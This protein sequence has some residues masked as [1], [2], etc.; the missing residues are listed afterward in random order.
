MLAPRKKL[1][2]TPSSAV[3][4]AL[5]LADLD[6]HDVVYDIG[7]GD[8]RVLIQLASAS[9][10][11]PSPSQ[12]DDTLETP[13][14]KEHE[15]EADG[16]CNG[17]D[18]SGGAEG[19]TNGCDRVDTSSEAPSPPSK[20]EQV[21]SFASPTTIPSDPQQQL[22]E[23]SNQRNDP[24]DRPNQNH[25]TRRHHHC[26]KFV[27]IE[28]SPERALE[29]QTNVQNA[30]RS[31][32]VPEHVAIEIRCMNALEVNYAHDATVCFLY[33]VPRG[34]RLMKPLLWGVNQVK[35]GGIGGA[36]GKECM[37]VD[38]GVDDGAIIACSEGGNDGLDAEES[39]RNEG[40]MD[41]KCQNDVGE[42]D[43]GVTNAVV[44]GECDEE[45]MLSSTAT[46]TLS[47]IV[48]NEQDEEKSHQGGTT[49]DDHDDSCMNEHNNMGR[50]M[51]KPRRIITYMAGFEDEQYVRKEHCQVEHQEGAA[52][53]IYLYHVNVV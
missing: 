18:G 15:N 35:G 48:R 30:R 5:E 44:F 29:A 19:A 47:D 33:L 7:C 13:I 38:D 9:L 6:E 37:D 31:K 25:R 49:S 4:I 16:K 24:K 26:R 28:I 8:G 21:P 17:H 10:P 51:M 45:A 2:S 36:R 12:N 53:P 34:L 46:P 23:P 41:G 3:D 11:L 52:W 1:W 32:L 14:A 43:F 27:G 20:G 50:T 22:R 39:V 42:L 40:M